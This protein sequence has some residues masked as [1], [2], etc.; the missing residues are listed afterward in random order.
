MRLVSSRSG[1][2]ETKNPANPH[3]VEC[4][5]PRALEC[6]RPPAARGDQ[7]YPTPWS[8]SR[9]RQEG[10][11]CRKGAA[12]RLLEEQRRRA[13]QAGLNFVGRERPPGCKRSPAL[14]GS[15]ARSFPG[16]TTHGVNA[17]QARGQPH[18]PRHRR[19]CGSCYFLIRASQC[20]IGCIFPNSINGRIVKR[21][22]REFEWGRGP[23]RA[24]QSRG[25]GA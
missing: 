22:R 23:S 1:S 7:D 8:R 21:H 5:A 25:P 9:V 20:F 13:S 16:L 4:P 14:Q 19:S 12:A 17:D 3:A 24:G 6:R 2:R 18:M 15:I 11:G 10:C